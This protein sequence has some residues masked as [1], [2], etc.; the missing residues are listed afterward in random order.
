M[1]YAMTILMPFISNW[2]IVLTFVVLQRRLPRLTALLAMAFLIPFRFCSFWREMC[3]GLCLCSGCLRRFSHTSFCADA[4]RLNLCDKCRGSTM[5]IRNANGEWKIQIWNDAKGKGNVERPN[6]PI[7][8]NV[9]S[10]VLCI[11]VDMGIIAKHKSH[12]DV[13]RITFA[14]TNP[15]LVLWS[16]LVPIDDWMAHQRTQY[17]LMRR[18]QNANN[19]QIFAFALRGRKITEKYLESFWM[20]VVISV[21]WEE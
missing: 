19:I 20:V 21:Q 7:M 18:D 12:F 16:L 14:P 6:F 15:P 10:D 2:K 1:R 4:E 13:I 8:I 3:V 11:T 17:T 5:P 9:I